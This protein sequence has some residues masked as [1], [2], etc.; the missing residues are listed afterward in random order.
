MPKRLRFVINRLYLHAP[1]ICLR[2]ASESIEIADSPIDVIAV[3]VRTD[4]TAN[5]PESAMLDNLVSS[6]Y[7]KLFR[8]V[9]GGWGAKCHHPLD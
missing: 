3:V 7:H 1:A 2:P 8:L 4:K 9:S 5:T 6:V